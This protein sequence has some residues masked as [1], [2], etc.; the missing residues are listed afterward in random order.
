[1][2]INVAFG[3]C[4]QLGP[5]RNAPEGGGF[6]AD[7]ARPLAACPLCQ[8]AEHPGEALLARFRALPA[9][10]ITQRLSELCGRCQDHHG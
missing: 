4:E 9:P 10:P 8:V 5:A 3:T 7:L 2:R 6:V 1:M